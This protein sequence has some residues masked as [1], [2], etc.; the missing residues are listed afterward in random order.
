MRS[1]R[2]IRKR[3]RRKTRKK[4]KGGKFECKPNRKGRY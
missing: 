4:K 2:K 3:M 1:R